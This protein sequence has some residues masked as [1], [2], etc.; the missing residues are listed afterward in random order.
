MNDKHKRV[1]NDALNDTEVSD[2]IS[3]IKATINSLNPKQ[4]HL[5][6]EWLYVWCSYIKNEKTFLP[7]KLKYYKRG[8]VVL[9]NFGYNVGSELGG[10]H[11]AVVVENNN[12]KTSNTVTVV[13]VSS[14]QSS[15]KESELH[16]SEVFL[17][18]IIPDSDKLSYA[19]PLQIRAI[20][21]LRII[22]PKTSA[23]G[24]YKI[25]NEKL[26]EIDEKIKQ[27]FTRVQA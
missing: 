10:A 17:G 23:D 8:E 9:A 7:Q 15:K 5:L 4:Q 12:N 14:L 27:L 20:S 2:I 1:F 19:M 25:S 16:H 22:K 11:Y 21:K 6:A 24:V 13:P 3:R 26:S 18:K